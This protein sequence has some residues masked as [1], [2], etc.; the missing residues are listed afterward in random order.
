ML[1]SFRRLKA[2]AEHDATIDPLTGL[3]NR[4]GGQRALEQM[5]ARAYRSGSPLGVV[6]FDLDHFKSINDRH[7][8]EAGDR[9]LA[10]VGEYVG[11]ALRLGDVAA[12]VGGDEFLL[13]LPDTDAAGAIAVAEKVR[14]GLAGLSLAG[15][16]TAVTASLG[17][18][19][20]CADETPT[21]LL[22]RV[23]HALYDSKLHGRNRAVAAD[24]GGEFAL[25]PAS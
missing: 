1:V 2:Q 12:R 8:H 11:D 10:A 13:L 21:A 22:R 19:C 4:R 24:I 7:G 25:Q 14:L 16:P 18:G 5:A 23:D 9:V 20:L 6:T 17:A 3:G 15:L